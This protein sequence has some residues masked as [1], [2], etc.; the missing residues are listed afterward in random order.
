MELTLKCQQITVKDWDCVA[1]KKRLIGNDADKANLN[2]LHHFLGYIIIIITTYL[3]LFSSLE[4]LL[5]FTF[6][7]Q[8]ILVII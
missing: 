4:L 8:S 3:I 5:I 1:E 6:L 7:C 2:I